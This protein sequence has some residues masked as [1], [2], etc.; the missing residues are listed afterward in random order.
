MEAWLAAGFQGRHFRFPPR[1]RRQYHADTRRERCRTAGMTGLLGAAVALLLYPVLLAAAPDMRPIAALLFLGGVVPLSVIFSVAVLF[2]PPPLAREILLALPVALDA[3]VLTYLFAR[4]HANATELYVAA[5]VLVL[6][7]AG[8]TVRLQF[9][10]AT[11]VSVYVFV[12]YALCLAVIR[13]EDGHH[14]RYLIVMTGAIAAYILMANWRLQVDQRR[15]YVM[16]LRERLRQHD[17]TARNQ[18]LDALARLDPLT[19]LANRRAYDLWLEEK[20]QDATDCD[21][22]LGLIML[23]VD[24]FKAFNDANGHPAG[25]ACLKAIAACL[26]DQLRRASDLVARLGG[27][28]FAVLLPGSTEEV[29]AA[30]AESLRSAIEALGLG[31]TAAD[32]NGVITISCGAASLKPAA[33]TDAALLCAAADRAMYWA[34]RAGRNRVRSASACPIGIPSE[35]PPTNRPLLGPARTLHMMDGRTA[36][37]ADTVSGWPTGSKKAVLL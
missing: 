7:Y 9:G 31:R 16:T 6:L 3:S 32:P 24:R 28:E 2:D 8:V 29:C 37:G 17:L 13:P 1:L 30:L 19:G 33:G 11:A 26:R 12:T 25:D 21:T 14:T 5:T 27:E 18:A 15:S 23:D 20:W 34:K 36:L 4:T 10:V 22:P 35:E